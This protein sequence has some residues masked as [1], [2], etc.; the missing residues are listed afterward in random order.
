MPD[1]RT[2]YDDAGY[3]NPGT[4]GGQGICC[5][6]GRTHCLGGCRETDLSVSVV[7]HCVVLAHEHVAKDPEGAVGL[8]D[9]H[10]HDGQDAQLV[11]PGIDDVLV[12]LQ[13]VVLRVWRMPFM[14]FTVM[15][16]TYLD[17]TI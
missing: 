8:R 17:N 9:V 12:A 5:G 4:R 13:G 3:R 2:Q 6:K 16:I 7:E 1:V 14:Y 10:G 15:Y 11:I